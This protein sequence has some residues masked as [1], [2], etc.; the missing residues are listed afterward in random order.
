MTSDNRTREEILVAAAVVDNRAR[1]RFEITVEG[2]TA[3]LDYQSTPKALTLIH[4]EVPE[5]L[6][7]R[8]LGP[9]LVETAVR[10]GRAEGLQIVIV[11]PFARAYLRAHPV[12]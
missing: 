8:G 12:P 3:T 1:R 11:C 7:G 5:A 10:A 2:L 4:T 6:R 9:R